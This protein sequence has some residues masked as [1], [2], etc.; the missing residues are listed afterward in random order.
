MPLMESKS[1][2]TSPM[3]IPLKDFEEETKILKEMWWELELRPNNGNKEREFI[4][5]QPKFYLQI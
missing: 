3:A 4:I 1:K 5:I 2:G